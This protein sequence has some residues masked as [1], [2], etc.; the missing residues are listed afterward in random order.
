MQSVRIIKRGKNQTLTE[1][2]VGQDQTTELQ[3]TREIVKTVK[4]WI[5]ELH[6]RRRDEQLGGSTVRSSAHY[7]L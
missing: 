7:F 4:G 5:T 3:S 2:E 6:R 1:L